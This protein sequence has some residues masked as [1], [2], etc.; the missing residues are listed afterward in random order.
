MALWNRR[1]FLEWSGKAGLAGLWAAPLL[2]GQE[3]AQ[4]T[5]LFEE[6]ISDVVFTLVTNGYSRSAEREANRAAVAV[7]DRLGYD[8]AALVTNGYY[9]H[10]AQ[11]RRA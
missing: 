1:Q 7:L 2:G 3:L 10:D 5:E 11:A 8:S 9:G 4:L 6:S